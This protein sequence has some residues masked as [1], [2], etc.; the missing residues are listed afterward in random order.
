[1]MNIIKRP[2]IEYY[3]KKYNRATTALDMWYQDFRRQSF[4]NPQEL[5][6]V[7]GTA[8]IVANQRVVFN[9]MGNKYRLVTMINYDVAVCY[10][11][12][13]GTHAEYDEINVETVKFEEKEQ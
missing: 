12:W 3:K 11:I 6:R 2:T 13:F 5:K 7:Y 9:I 1:M 4:K 10:I 8:S